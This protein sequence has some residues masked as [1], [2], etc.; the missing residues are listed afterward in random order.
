MYPR[1]T[2]SQKKSDLTA[3]VEQLCR[4]NH[5][6]KPAMTTLAPKKERMIVETLEP[7]VLLSADFLTIAPIL[8][9][10]IDQLDDTL[11]DFFSSE[12]LNTPL[13]GISLNEQIGEQ[14]P[15]SYAPTLNNLMSIDVSADAEDPELVALNNFDTNKDGKLTIQ[16]FLSD[17][18]IDKVRTFLDDAAGKT[19]DALKNY[20]DNELEAGISK[21]L[22]ISN[23][24]YIDNV[25]SLDFSFTNTQTLPI[26]LGVQAENLGIALKSDVD[27]KQSLGFTLRFGVNDT[28]GN[29]TQDDFF[30]GLKDLSA[31]VDVNTN[32]LDADINFGFL[33]ASINNGSIALNASVKA[34][35]VQL[36]NDELQD[37]PSNTFNVEKV[38]GELD[39]NLPIQV[40]A[41]LGDF[42][43]EGLV[44]D[45]TVDPFAQSIDDR[46]IDLDLNLDA[47]FDELLKFDTINSS[48]LISLL[49]QSV[50]FLDNLGNSEAISSFEIPFTK[51]SLGDVLDFADTFSDTLLYDDQDDSD[52]ENDVAKLLNPNPGEDEKLISFDTAQELATLLA[53]NTDAKYNSETQEL[54]YSLNFSH[55]LFDVE[56]PLN[57]DL[58][59]APIGNITSD[60]SLLLSGEAGMS[61]TLGLSLGEVAGATVLDNALPLTV[62]A[63]PASS[64]QITAN[65]NVKG[66]NGDGYKKLLTETTLTINGVDVSIQN[67]EGYNNV[68]ELVHALNEAINDSS[69]TGQVEFSSQGNRLIISTTDNFS[70][71]LTVAPHTELG[72]IAESGETV[73]EG[74]NHDFIITDQ[75][76]EEY[77]ISLE[78]KETITLSELQETIS[79]ATDDKVTLGTNADKTALIL[80]DTQ[81]NAENTDGL[82][83]LTPTNGSASAFLLGIF[84]IDAN[85]EQGEKADGMIEGQPI[86]GASLGDRFFMEDAKLWGDI[87]IT[88][89]SVVPDDSDPSIVSDDSESSGTT[90]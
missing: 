81:F 32:D 36:S 10:G 58:D 35:D 56:V 76:G 28:D 4:I 86:A 44:I 40:K 8:S 78:G 85:T 41:G 46:R 14:T 15:E 45:V 61:L 74:N 29:L 87:D 21:Y 51:S 66:L 71:T 50:N 62:N 57:F 77:G 33:G 20:L 19:S 22:N 67:Q 80:T 3:L 70:G 43:P 72:F 42:N 89:Q 84:G 38:N 24:S 6:A 48:D 53:D 11:E 82:F 34:G 59:L 83:S 75:S 27:V 5:G 12:L 60:A 13:P 37:I 1:F 90:D 26:D 2:P 47:N 39:I 16:E 73:I 88:T 7:R 31:E 17:G 54:S 30:I 69:L 9:D 23:V 63:N 18:V 25:V 79:S 68:F 65:E 64:M 55:E 52:P 49:Q